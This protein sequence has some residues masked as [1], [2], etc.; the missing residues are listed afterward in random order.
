MA[1]LARMGRLV[2]SALRGT[3]SARQRLGGRIGWLVALH[4]LV[5]LSVSEIAFQA[6]PFR[7]F[8]AALHRVALASM[9]GEPMGLEDPLA[10]VLDVA[11][12]A[13]SVLVFATL[14]GILGSYF[15]ERRAEQE[16]PSAPARVPINCR[17]STRGD[18]LD[19][20]SGADYP[21]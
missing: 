14:A 1:R 11:L 19:G 7:S 17:R 16:D 20:L 12:A 15:L 4:V 6:L 5:V 21:A 2:S 9:A 8:G 3:R 13:Y 10:L 18:R